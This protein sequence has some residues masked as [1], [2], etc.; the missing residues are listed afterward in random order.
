[1]RA[2]LLAL[3][4]AGAAAARPAPIPAEMD[5][6]VGHPHPNLVANATFRRWPTPRLG[7]LRRRFTDLPASCEVLIAVAASSV[8]PAD[9]KGGPGP[10]PQ[11]LGSDV[12]GTVIATE[13]HCQRA[14]VGDRV[15]A[16][17]GAV[18]YYTGEDGSNLTGQEHGAYAQI[19]VALES[20]IGPMP[21][22]VGFEEAASLP[23]VA[24][25]S[26][27]GLVWYGGAPYTTRP[28]TLILGGSGG[29]GTAAIQI[30]RALGAGRIITTT[31][32]DNFDYVRRLGADK[33]IDYR[34]QDWWNSSVLAD[35]SV[36]VVFD[37]V[38][39]RGT[40]DRAMAKLRAGGW[41]VTLK[42]TLPD[43]P[44]ADVTSATFK[45]SATN[46]DNLRELEALRALVEAGKLRMPGLKSYP[47]SNVT[48][49]FAES[50]A[51]QVC[52]KLSVLIPP[53]PSAL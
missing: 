32:A 10:F 41:Y 2:A 3:P 19:A 44:R 30:A 46:L 18:V 39:Q 35:A 45:N 38:G 16:D 14:R 25:T 9:R 28:T 4:A 52:G 49:A 5:A 51:G 21:H 13:P 27:K 6:Y 40:G 15:W 7:D 37:A 1:M 34:T 50:A 48:G 43:H 24:L 33:A 26:Y 22:N 20:Q 29:C 17:L 11:V 36:D 42:A 53:A 12:A 23:K 47:L 8:N 31:S